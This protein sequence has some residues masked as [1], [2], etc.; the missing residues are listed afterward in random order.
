M[1]YLFTYNGDDFE[2]WKSDLHGVR[3]YNIGIEGNIGYENIEYFID[4]YKEY[5]QAFLVYLTENN[6]IK[7]KREEEW[8][9]IYQSRAIEIIHQ[10]G[11][12][13]V[14]LDSYKSTEIWDLYYYMKDVIKQLEEI[15][16]KINT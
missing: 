13:W 5:L 15:K 2:V 1:E 12:Y 9:R 3:Y 7:P 16:D 11:Y 14:F 8:K 6:Y 10:D 4:L